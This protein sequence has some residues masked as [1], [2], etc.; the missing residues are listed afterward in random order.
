MVAPPDSPGRETDLVKGGDDQGER[1]ARLYFIILEEKGK[2]WYSLRWATA[3]PPEFPLR[4]IYPAS[5][6]ETVIADYDSLRTEPSDPARFTPPP[7]F[8]SVNPF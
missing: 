8:L 1:E 7:D 5:D 4:T 2:K 3:D 6:Y